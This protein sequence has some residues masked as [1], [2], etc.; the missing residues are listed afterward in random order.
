M[1][2][3]HYSHFPLEI[4]FVVDSLR[5]QTG[6]TEGQ[7]IHILKGLD[8]RRFSPVLCCLYKSEW[9]TRNFDFCPVYEIGT[10]RPLRPSSWPKI[11]RL[12]NFFSHH[13]VQIIHTFF[14]DANIAGVVAGR[15]AGVPIII[16]SR[17]NKGY[18]QN[19]REILVLKFL[20]RWVTRFM[21]NSEDVRQYTHDAE[22]VPLEKVD[23]IY[24]GLDFGNYPVV[25]EN[26][27]KIS[28]KC[29]DL[30]EESNAV[31][32]VANLRP[33]KGI[34]VL[35]NAL[36]EIARQNHEVIILFVGEGDERLKLEKLVER[37][38]L[39][40]NVR[41]LGTRTDVPFILNACDLGVLSSH[42][43]SLSNSIIEY[44]ASG[45][46]VVAT[47]VGGTREMIT[48]GE[49]GFLVP[50]GDSQALAQAII[51]VLKDSELRMKMGHIGREKAKKM[52][53]L[54]GCVKEHEEYY[55]GLLKQAG[56]LY[57]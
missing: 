29:L 46:A 37:Y 18:W 44:M 19:R 21:A 26:A 38:G 42:S 16:S 17:R 35:I 31:V 52:F 12:A 51:K 50:R 33:V 3:K 20:N 15:L 41:F 30:P 55:I 27:R 14:R 6:G 32:M 48:H 13:K 23:V 36:P 57:I 22:G 39:S 25:T 9:M 4:I 34:D 2:N 56:R 5:L 28:R 45:L 40:K 24:N 10:Q 47:D 54:E 53:N 49:N 43:E 7:I 1:L 11:F 8:R